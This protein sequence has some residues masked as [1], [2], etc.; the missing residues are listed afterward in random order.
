ME[1]LEPPETQLLEIRGHKIAMRGYN[2]ECPG[3]PTVFIHGILLSNSFWEPVLP[4]SVRYHRPYYVL[5]LPGHYPS[6]FPETYTPAEITAELFAELHAEAI[7]RS[8]GDRSVRLVGWSTGGFSVLNVAGRYPELAERVLC[9]A[10]FSRGVWLGGVLPLHAGPRI[11]PLVRWL[12]RM[13]MPRVMGSRRLYRFFF[14]RGVADGRAFARYPGIDE[15]LE[16]LRRDAC[17]HDPRTMATLFER[18]PEFNIVPLLGRISSPTWIAGGT[19]DPF[20]PMSETRFLAEQIPGARLIEFPGA[21]HM[22]FAERPA[23]W[24]ETLEAFLG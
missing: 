21:G 8:V 17:G 1:T 15:L 9:I 2:L 12:F 22:F 11:G 20:I 18:I 13:L 3:T 4:D 16:T 7:R 14:R 5:S 6:Q 10:G 23:L 24:H 19:D